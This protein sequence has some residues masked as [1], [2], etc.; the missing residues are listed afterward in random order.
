M[1]FQDLGPQIGVGTKYLGEKKKVQTL[2]DENGIAWAQHLGWRTKTEVAL[3]GENTQQT[4]GPK[5]LLKDHD[6]LFELPLNLAVNYAGV[7]YANWVVC[8]I[9]DR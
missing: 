1:G 6:N 7:V 4:I 3:W 9:Y 5:P 2:C 8:Q